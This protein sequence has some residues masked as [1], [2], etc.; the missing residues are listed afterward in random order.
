MTN[1]PIENQAEL[2]SIRQT[3]D[4]IDLKQVLRALRRQRALIAK[5]AIATVLVSGLYAVIKKPVWEG[6]FEIV[7]A[8][9]Q[10]PS[11][12]A[13]SLLQSNPGLAKLIGVS[14]NDQLETE[15]EILQSP[16]VLNL[17]LI[18]SNNRMNSRY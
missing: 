10:S 16:S 4:E 18:L 8:S 11:S 1:H 17:Y 3:Y 9:T 12:Q 5:V 6:Q 7:L 2:P 13:S 15:V 14:N